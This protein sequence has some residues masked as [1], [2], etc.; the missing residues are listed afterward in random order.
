[1]TNS[2]V[3]LAQVKQIMFHER[4]PG[5]ESYMKKMREGKNA[6]HIQATRQQKYQ[7]NGWRENA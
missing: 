1:M 7:I 2:V 3:D 4:V 5:K 6:R